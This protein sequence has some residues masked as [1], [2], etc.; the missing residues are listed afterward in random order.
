VKSCEKLYRRPIKP[1]RVLDSNSSSSRGG[2]V[3]VN[4]PYAVCTCSCRRSSAL[5]V[6]TDFDF[7]GAGCA[8]PSGDERAG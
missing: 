3:S 8:T 6:K 7:A 4:W 2:L 1:L 5:E